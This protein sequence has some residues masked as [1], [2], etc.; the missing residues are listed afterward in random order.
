M[1]DSKPHSLRKHFLGT[2]LGLRL[3]LL[4]IA[5]L[6]PFALWWGGSLAEGLTLRGSMSA[7]YHT[8]LR[9]VFVGALFG[10]GALLVAYQGFSRSENRALDL[11][12]LFVIG[13]ALIREPLGSGS[14]LGFEILPRVADG[15]WYQANGLMLLAPSAFFIIGLFIW[16][17]RAWKPEQVEAPEYEIA[18]NLQYK[19]AM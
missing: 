2:Y 8:E 16:A 7:Y 10:V 13:V 6:L 9:D 4:G 12:S 19:E 18:P 15:G 11:A 14:L 5:V 1:R 3:G 17:I